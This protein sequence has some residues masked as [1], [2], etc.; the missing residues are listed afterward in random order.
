MSSIGFTSGKERVGR[1]LARVRR[2]NA[3][4][5]VQA[6][7]NDAGV[8]RQQ[9]YDWEKLGPPLNDETFNRVER[10]Y[11]LEAGTLM[12]EMFVGRGDPLDYWRKRVEEVQ[13]V[14]ANAV[15]RL[16]ALSA[17]MGGTDELS[18]APADEE[19]EA[20]LSDQI[21]EDEAGGDRPAQ[22]AG[23]AIS[24]RSGEEGG[25]RGRFAQ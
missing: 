6:I 2:E 3:A 18:P 21:A 1:L 13:E 25:A 16:A 9:V 24:P 5:T 15:S 20:A 17:E 22:G 12:A 23:Q 11:R 7:A 4:L 10:A 19:I 14:V 8:S